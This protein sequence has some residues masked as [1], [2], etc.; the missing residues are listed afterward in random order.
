MLADSFESWGSQIEAGLRRMRDRGE[1]A[2]TADPK[3][4]AIAILGAV[5]GG[6]LL[7]KTMRAVR[8]VQ[9]TLEMA[10]ALVERHSTPV[11]ISRF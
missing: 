10:L 1:F 4:L 7:A 3:D 2:K 11:G 5:Q 6:L 9:L 8:P